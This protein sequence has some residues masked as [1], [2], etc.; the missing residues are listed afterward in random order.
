MPDRNDPTEVRMRWCPACGGP[1]PTTE[2][3][4]PAAP[5]QEPKPPGSPL[6]FLRGALR[7]FLSAYPEAAPAS[8]IT[9]PGVRSESASQ[10]KREE[11]E[12]CDRD[13]R[14]LSCASP[15]FPVPFFD[16]EPSPTVLWAEARRIDALRRGDTDQW[17]AL[18]D[19]GARMMLGVARRMLP[20]ESAAQEA[21]R[22]AILRIRRE[23]GLYKHVPAFRYWQYY[24]LSAGR[25]GGFRR[26]PPSPCFRL[27]A[28]V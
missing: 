2:P 9:N 8:D 22:R 18:L 11:D 6:R 19:G 10:G 15:T 24:P 13:R 27:L 14:C 26:F 21:V 25:V 17:S 3:D 28:V 4:A 16:R 5:E 7:D 20:D 23:I 12:R 1:Q